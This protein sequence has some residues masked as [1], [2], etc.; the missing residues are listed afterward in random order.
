VGYLRKNNSNIFK[1][2]LDKT[3]SCCY[4][5]G[6]LNEKEKDI[7]CPECCGNGYDLDIENETG[8]EEDCWVCCGTGTTTGEDWYPNL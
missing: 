5:K 7:A 6:M 3:C 2:V 4:N 8:E 1:I